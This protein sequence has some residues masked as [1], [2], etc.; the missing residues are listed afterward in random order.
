M[1][2]AFCAQIINYKL[3]TY[4]L[5]QF[6]RPTGFSSL[7]KSVVTPKGFQLDKA[8]LVVIEG[9]KRYKH[10]EQVSQSTQETLGS[11]PDNDKYQQIK[12][13]EKHQC[14]HKVKRGMQLAVLDFLPK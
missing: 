13:G 12:N 9:E 7:T 3:L 11:N 10:Q 6:L 14:S 1:N 5:F 8:T 2:N 4:Q